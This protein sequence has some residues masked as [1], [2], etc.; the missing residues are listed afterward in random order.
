M[1]DLILDTDIG[2]DDAY[3][4]RLALLTGR[5][6]GVTTTYGNESIDKTTKNAKLSLRKWQCQDVGVCRGA[7]QPLVKPRIISDGHIFGQD[8]LGDH[9]ENPETPDAPDAISYIVNCARERPGEITLATIGPLTNLALALNLEPRLPSLL[10]QVISM[11]GAF[12]KNG[13]T[14]NMTHFA[15][16]NIYCDPHA[17]E[18]V[19]AAPFNHVLIPIDMTHDVIIDEQEMKAYQDDF[20]Y[21]IS[22]FYLDFSEKYEKFRGMCVHDALTLV[23]FEHPE[24][25]EETRTPIAVSTAGITLGQTHRRLSS[26]QSIPDDVMRGRPEHTVILNG[27]VKAI[28][29]F[30]LERMLG[31][32]A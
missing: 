16:F 3:A 22:L 9:Y 28:K 26:Y 5:L 7:S 18:Q 25:F 31:G 23:Y 6:L 4:L 24:F 15:E 12:G 2:V 17:A 20:L 30:M 11:G 27:D 13:H 10:R 8:G 32:K 14:G 19:F 21:N 29:E 1:R